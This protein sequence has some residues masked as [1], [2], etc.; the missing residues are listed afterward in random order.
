MSYAALADLVE[1]YG[2]DEILRLSDR[3]GTGEI[4]DDIVNKALEDATAEI[5]TYLSGRYNLPL[6]PVPKVIK[7]LA[8]DIARY[9]LWEDRASE[10]VRKRYEDV[11]RMLEQM[12]N[13]LIVLPG[14]ANGASG[15]MKLAPARKRDWGML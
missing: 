8:C 12:A 1:R 9:L 15:T 4:N 5:D 7:R 2:E 14:Y 6:S 13:G 10:E 3:E 11:K